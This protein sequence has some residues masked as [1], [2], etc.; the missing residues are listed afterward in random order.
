[1]E[2]LK[3]NRE[4]KRVYKNGKSYATRNLVIYCLPTKLDKNRYGF[5]V[6]KRVGKAV[7]RNKIKRRLKE[8]VREFEKQYNFKAYDIIFIARN[9][10]VDLDFY[11]LKR[12][13]RRLYRKSGLIK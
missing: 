10:I 2:S 1:M 6:S 8:I 13:V 3:K 12:D 4:F 9:P 7:I 11:Q 5:S